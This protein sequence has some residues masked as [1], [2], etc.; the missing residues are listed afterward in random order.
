MR[1]EKGR[2]I[3]EVA[4]E[5]KEKGGLSSHTLFCLQEHRVLLKQDRIVA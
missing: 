3:W 4:S 2:A 1:K 5:V